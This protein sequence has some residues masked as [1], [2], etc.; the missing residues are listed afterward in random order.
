M[1]SDRFEYRTLSLCSAVNLGILTAVSLSHMRYPYLPVRG[2]PGE[3][4]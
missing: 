4:G 1:G 3:G 2:D